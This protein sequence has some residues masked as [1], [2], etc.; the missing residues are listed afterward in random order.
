MVCAYVAASI[1]RRRVGVKSATG[2]RNTAVGL[3]KG[4]RPPRL[5][6][7]SAVM[8]MRWQT[9]AA[10]MCAVAAAC[11]ADGV[12]APT[13]KPVV[14]TAE[15]G[16][17]VVTPPVAPVATAGTHYVEPARFDFRRAR[18]DAGVIGT[19]QACDISYVNKRTTDSGPVVL[20]CFGHGVHASSIDLTVPDDVLASFKERTQ[21]R[22]KIDGPGRERRG[23]DAEVSLI[24][25]AGE[26]EPPPPPSRCLCDYDREQDHAEA[27]PKPFAFSKFKDARDKLWGTT[28]ICKVWSVGEIMKSSP[29]APEYSIGRIFEPDELPYAA[30][31]TCA[32]DNGSDEVVV[33]SES[34]ESLLALDEGQSI[35]IELGWVKQWSWKTTGRLRGIAYTSD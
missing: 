10:M 18:L 12:T 9:A 8:N 22:V 2:I 3:A 25:I 20:N 31:I 29:E 13:A 17:A 6:V 32:W 27:A 19:T 28:Q 14:V 23:A 5:R 4:T 11:G 33:G 16:A 35:R 34:L 26:I 24:E 7:T 21:L 15:A 30:E 1:G